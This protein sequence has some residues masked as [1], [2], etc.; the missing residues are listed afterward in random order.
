MFFD[1][2]FEKENGGKTSWLTVK[3][4][5][6]HTAKF[7]CDKNIFMKK[8]ETATDVAKAKQ[9]VRHLIHMIVQMFVL[10]D[11]VLF[12]SLSWYILYYEGEL[13]IYAAV[14]KILVFKLWKTMI[15]PIN[16]DIKS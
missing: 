7:I 6:T 11:V 14:V 3:K 4:Q 9:T 16:Y 10:I 15:E 1:F 5:W 13:M 12:L 8:T 2:E